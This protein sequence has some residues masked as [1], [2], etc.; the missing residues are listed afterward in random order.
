MTNRFGELM[1][2]PHVRAIQEEMGSRAA[3]ARFMGPGTP[4]RD[5]LGNTEMNFIPARE[6]FYL[7]TVSENGWP[8]VQHRG[9]ASGFVKILDDRTI[10]FADFRG[11]QQYISAGNLATDDRVC[12]FLMDYP[13]RRR[14]KLLGHARTVHFADEPDLCERLRDPSYAAVVERGIVIAIEGF[15]WNCPQHIT[16]RFSEEEIERMLTPIRDRMR[17]LEQENASLKASLKAAGI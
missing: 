3:Y 8:Y 16:P 4:A 11:N 6:S 13:N 14:L 10:G 9:G 12:V 15:D 5:R 7:A 17:A 2:T 1:F